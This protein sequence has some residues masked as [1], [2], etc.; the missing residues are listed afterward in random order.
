[1]ASPGRRERHL[2]VVESLHRPVQTLCMMA[3]ALRKLAQPRVR[4]RNVSKSRERQRPLNDSRIGLPTL[5]LSLP[6]GDQ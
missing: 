5:I 6:T 3:N 1:M 2:A 4:A